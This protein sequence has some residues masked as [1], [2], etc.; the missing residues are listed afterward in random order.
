LAG[1]RV[2]LVEDNYVVAR[3]MFETLQRMG[4]TVKGPFGSLIAATTGYDG[5]DVALV[6]VNVRGEPVF[7][8]ADRLLRDGIPVA[9]VT[10]YDRSALPIGFR[11]LPLIS[12]PVELCTLEAVL[13]SMLRLDAEAGV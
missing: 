1:V 10:G 8:L 6:D 4:A 2:L 5:C 7:P 3:E 12:K 13:Q 9:L 11:A